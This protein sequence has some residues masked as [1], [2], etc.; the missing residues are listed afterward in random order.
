MDGLLVRCLD[1]DEE[2][3][4]WGIGNGDK[5]CSDPRVCDVAGNALAEVWKKPHLFDLFATRQV[6]DRQLFELK[7][8][9]RKKQ[10]QPPLPLPTPR[11]VAALSAEKV[12]PLCEAV[13]A[14]RTERERRAALG[15][16]ENLGLP[17]VPALRNF[18]TKAPPKHPG[19]TDLDALLVRL[20]L[21]VSEVRFADDS[22]RPEKE[23][24]QAIERWKGRPLTSTDAV[25][26]LISACSALPQ[27]AGGARVAVRRRGDDTGSVVVVW[28]TRA[29]QGK[30]PASGW[31][32]SEGIEVNG[33]T[34]HSV[35]S[36]LPG[37]NPRPLPERDHWAEFVR[38]LDEKVR[39]TRKSVAILLECR[40][41]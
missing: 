6:R 28:L 15:R 11:K 37:G 33:E 9:W 25:G 13:L 7:N 17:A 34:V 24:R 41:Q 3:F 27:G 26:L 18:L 31:S 14:A 23:L 35:G 10:G 19:R 2:P 22:V 1:D 36:G 21:T 12:H 16:L 30:E 4:G 8:L 5:L 38:L 40:E 32:T 29:R 39:D 20:A